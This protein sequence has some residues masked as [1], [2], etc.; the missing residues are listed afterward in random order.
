VGSAADLT[1]GDSVTVSGTANSD[2]SMSATSI[3]IRPTQNQ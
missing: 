2:G 3:Q 1:V